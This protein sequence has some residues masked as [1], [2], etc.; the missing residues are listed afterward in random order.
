M[1]G[2]VGVAGDVQVKHERAFSDLLIMNQL[3]GFDSIGVTRVNMTASPSV[4]KTLMHPAE[5]IA[6]K[7]YK[8][9]LRSSNRVLLGHNRAAT[10][11]EVNVENAHPF[12]HGAITGVHNGTLTYR[13]DLEEHERFKVDSDNLFYHLHKK[14]IKDLWP[15]IWGAAAL[16]W[17]D[18]EKEELNFIRNKERPLFFALDKEK[19]VLVWASEFYML[20]AATSRNGITMNATP[21]AAA[22]N[23]LY[24]FS[25]KDYKKGDAVKLTEEVISDRP[26]IIHFPKKR[27]IV[28]YGIQKAP[29]WLIVGNT[30]DCMF[31]SQY[32]VNGFWNFEGWNPLDDRI[33]IEASFVKTDM[34]PPVINL[35]NKTQVY[36]GT[37]K[38]ITR[39]WRGGV[40]EF[41]VRVERVHPAK[42]ADGSVLLL[43]DEKKIDTKEWDGVLA[44]LADEAPFDKAD[45]SCKTLCIFQSADFCQ[46]C[47]QAFFG[48][49]GEWTKTHGKRYHCDWCGG[50]HKENEI[51]YITNDKE[52]S[53]C[54]DCFQN[55][56]N[57]LISRR[58]Y[59]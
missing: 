27:P 16:V 39:V 50:V 13:R 51:V 49:I 55:V 59:N 8:D 23:T 34:A 57:H 26:I 43:G 33:N 31:E 24:T 18:S 4:L 3:R 32:A 9:L 53:Y 21:M 42:K 25:F 47:R 45:I 29:A 12:T 5:L 17:W 30:I 15:K 48:R 56:V 37:I 20:L 11:G 28:D 7:E 2:I 46:K 41:D 36:R 22:V 58:D 10:V 52:E 40:L 35:F 44:S 54:R 6:S 14:G 38:S 19:K 1:C